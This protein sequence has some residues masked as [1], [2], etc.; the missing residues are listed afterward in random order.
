MKSK[1]IY[2]A[3]VCGGEI[4]VGDRVAFVTDLW[5]PR[6]ATGTVTK[7]Y[8]SEDVEDLPEYAEQWYIKASVREDNGQVVS[9]VQARR[10][11]KLADGEPGKA[12]NCTFHLDLRSL[13]GTDVIEYFK[14]P[15]LADAI[16]YAQIRCARALEQA[17][18]ECPDDIEKNKVRICKVDP[19]KY[20]DNDT[21]A[22]G[23]DP[24]CTDG[25]TDS[26]LYVCLART[27]L[28]SNAPQIPPLT[29]REKELLKILAHEGSGT[30]D[31]LD[32]FAK[33]P[34]E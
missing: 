11:Y 17:W 32:F 26:P 6:I 27:P 12:E 3:K 4:K 33:H 24:E 29:D 1:R 34:A 28:K 19:E 14:A 21:I 20:M 22:I 8:V 25:W 10:M 2:C 23:L 9:R 7:I 18:M 13:Y 5:D 31:L 15:T 16:S 30:E